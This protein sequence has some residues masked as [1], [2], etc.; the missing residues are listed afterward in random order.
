MYSSLNTHINYNNF[1]ELI[2]KLGELLYKA[3]LTIDSRQI[4][5]N[6][7]FFAYKGTHLDGRDF[8]PLVKDVALCIIE[9]GALNLSI[10]NHYT[11][12]HVQELVGI[13]SSIKY[14]RPSNQM[15]VV[16]VTGTNGKTSI[17]QWLAQI[18]TL[19]HIQSGL[20]G[21]LGGGIYPNTKDYSST[22]PNPITLQNILSEF[23]IHKTRAVFMEVSSHSLVQGRVN[24]VKFKT[25][26]FTN[27]TQDHLDYH[28]TMENYYLAKKS[29]FYWK[30]L[31]Y[32]VINIDDEYGSR[33]HDELIKDNTGVKIITYGTL[34]ANQYDLKA[35]DID[36]NIH[37]VHFI[38]HYKN[39]K[40]PIYA[41]IIGKFNV[42]NLLATIGVLITQ[43]YDLKT[44]AEYVTQ[45][46]PVTGRM[47]TIKKDN[48]P[49]VVIDYA[50]TPDALNNT[51]STLKEI[52]HTGKI[53]CLFGCGGDRDHTKRRVMGEIAVV[54]S[55]YVIITSDNPRTE[56]PQNIINDIL[57]DISSKKYNNYAVEVDRKTAIKRAINLSTAQDIILIAGKG[58]ETY[59]EIFGIKHHFSDFEI[60]EECLEKYSKYQATS[61]NFDQ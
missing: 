58:H 4:D 45:I 44:I 16:G 56:E 57:T 18:N 41:Q 30:N 32:A 13:I 5:S 6:S 24:G 49:L 36:I 46:K 20:I 7:I 39:I 10:P 17:A 11:I 1:P 12:E 3:N 15:D 22:T 59:Q 27:L 35:T 61:P 28:G 31:Q 23:V 55:D 42:Y 14:N 37:G 50:H 38:L 29:L 26:V 48:C 53:Y 51:L 43:G 25:A 40:T 19:H 34:D 60:A 8:I 21:T 2:L 52:S 47:D 54:H 33:L 9:E